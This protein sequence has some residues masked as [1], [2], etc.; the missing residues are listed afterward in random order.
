M[1]DAVV[2][3]YNTFNYRSVTLPEHMR[4]PPLLFGFLLLNFKF[5]EYI[6]DHWF[7]FFLFFFLLAIVLSVPFR[8]TTSDYSFSIFI[9]FLHTRNWHYNDLVDIIEWYYRYSIEQFQ[10]L[11]SWYNTMYDILSIYIITNWWSQITMDLFPFTYIFS[12]L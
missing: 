7:F 9:L 5:S 10:L 8:I 4:S 12:F 6:V 3:R 11:N 1:V 2:L